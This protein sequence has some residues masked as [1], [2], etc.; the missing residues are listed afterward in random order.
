MLDICLLKLEV[1][2]MTRVAS[3][4][5]RQDYHQINVNF[6]RILF[7]ELCQCHYPWCL[8]CNITFL[9][10]LSSVCV[11]TYETL[12]MSGSHSSSKTRETPLQSKSI[13]VIARYGV[14]VEGSHG[15][16]KYHPTVTTT[17]N[18]LLDM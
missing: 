2:M 3:P 6:F 14:F 7:V 17:S 9:L 16:L 1:C 18:P 13:Y 15:L 8:R 12:E 5:H 4:F 10:L 11:C